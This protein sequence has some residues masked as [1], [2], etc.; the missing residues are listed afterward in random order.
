[1][2]RKYV[3]CEISQGTAGGL[4]GG[5]E[6]VIGRENAI[7]KGWFKIKDNPLVYSLLMVAG[8]ICIVPLELYVCRIPPAVRVLP[9]LENSGF[10]EA[11]VIAACSIPD[12]HMLDQNVVFGRVQPAFVDLVAVIDSF[13]DV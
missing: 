2:A 1:M 4:F 7:F 8:C 9:G 3:P 6:F 11:F 13:A 10:F 12:L 5:V